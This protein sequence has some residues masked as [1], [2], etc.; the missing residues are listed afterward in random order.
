MRHRYAG[1]FLDDV[2]WQVNVSTASSARSR[3]WTRRAGSGRWRGW[4][5]AC[6][7]RRAGRREVMVNTVWWRAESS[8][9][10][11][12]VRG[13]MQRATDLYIERGT[14]DTRRGQSYEGCWR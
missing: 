12:V 4:S 6:A 1:V 11:P 13:G 14:E 7:T 8:L 3:P 5:A 2:N 9:D 10:D